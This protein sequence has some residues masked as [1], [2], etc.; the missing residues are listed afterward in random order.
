MNEYERNRKR[1]T[2]PITRECQTLLKDFQPFEGCD[3][4][5]RIRLLNESDIDL[6]AAYTDAVRQATDRLDEAHAYEMQRMAGQAEL[7]RLLEA[8]TR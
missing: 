3:M 8:H 7:M 2:G 4:C 6:F 1:A 5:R